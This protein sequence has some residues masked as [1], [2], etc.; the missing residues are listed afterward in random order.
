M[1]LGRAPVLPCFVAH[2]STHTQTDP[3]GDNTTPL[4]ERD[5]SIFRRKGCY[6]IPADEERSDSSIFEIGTPGRSEAKFRVMSRV[7]STTATTS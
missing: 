3:E 4:V 2:A 6:A 7:Q 5:R 1:L